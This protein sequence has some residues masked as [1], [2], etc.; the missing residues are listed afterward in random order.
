M[1]N[2]N[3]MRTFK[4]YSL[5]LPLI[6]LFINPVFAVESNIQEAKQAAL[7]FVRY[8]EK[9]EMQN[10]YK[11]MSVDLKERLRKSNP[12]IKNG[13]EYAKSFED[14]ECIWKNF[15]ISGCKQSL[16][17]EAVCK[18]T[19]IIDCGDE[20][21]EY[22]DKLY[23]VFEDKKWKIDGWGENIREA[24]KQEQLNKSK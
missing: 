21:P 13:E 10:I 8:M 19:G 20:N 17:G 11:I 4:S 12:E 7:S 5:I 3:Y 22:K 6:F 14:Y 9:D 16:N 23:L 15:K 18:M 1:N 24:K 2:T